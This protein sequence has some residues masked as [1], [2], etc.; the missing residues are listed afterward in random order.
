[1]CSRGGRIQFR[2]LF[3]LR[4]QKRARHDS[5]PLLRTLNAGQLRFVSAALDV[6]I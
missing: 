3:H 4:F 2:Q 5:G 1:M 6:K